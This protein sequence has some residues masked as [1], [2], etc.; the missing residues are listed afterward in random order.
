MLTTFGGL[1]D[2]KELGGHDGRIHFNFVNTA[3]FRLPLRFVTKEN[4]A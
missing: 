2:R 4:K 3:L 1:E